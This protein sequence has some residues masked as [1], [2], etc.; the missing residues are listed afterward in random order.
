V[1]IALKVD[2]DTFE[3]TREGIPSLLRL[4]DSLGIRATFFFSLGPD[5]SGRALLRVFTRKG[6]LR[7]MWRSGAPSLY[8]P[9]TL[10]SGTLL[11]API[12]GE[13]CREVIRSVAAA[14]HETGG[15][16]W[17]HISWHD[18]LSRWSDGKIRSEFARMHEAYAGIFGRP[19]RATAAPG[20]TVS[21]AYL[22]VR[23]EFGLDYTSDTREGAPFRPVFDS[24]PSAV[25]E[26]PTTMPT[27]DELLGD[28][29][30]R[31]PE[32][33]TS[34]YVGLLR[35]EGLSVHT[36]HTEVEGRSQREWFGGLLRQWRDRGAEFTTLGE[37]AAG[38]RT[39][40]ENLPRKRVAP[41]TLPGRAGTVAS[42]TGA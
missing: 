10:L 36:I 32:A 27:L 18:G 8:G 21:D 2:C 9:R 24:Q 1:R 39:D 14:G 6:F 23:E 37:I 29:R 42:A 41:V 16:A 34:H 40:L 3:G 12:I 35:G 13:R 5:N 33:L 4:F 38:L 26:I 31:T 22:A 17:D 11:P 20:W 25:P 15:H 7:K 28:P 30:L 19:P